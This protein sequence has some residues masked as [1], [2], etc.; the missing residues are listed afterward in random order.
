MKI[1]I[2]ASEKDNLANLE[3]VVIEHKLTDEEL[4]CNEC[5]SELVEIGEKSRKAVFFLGFIISCN[6]KVLKTSK[7]LR[8]Q[9]NI[10]S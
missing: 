1:E 9:N 8:L 2:P 4:K 7:L 3:R 10:L 6:F 5:G